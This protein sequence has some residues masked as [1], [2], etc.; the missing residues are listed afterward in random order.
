[1]TMLAQQADPRA[2]T[3]IS[4]ARILFPV[5]RVDLQR[6]TASNFSSHLRGCDTFKLKLISFPLQ[7][8]GELLNTRRVSCAS[9][10]RRRRHR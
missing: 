3:R 5:M 7:G 2:I 9:H 10:D 1:M 6:A 4:S 8:Q